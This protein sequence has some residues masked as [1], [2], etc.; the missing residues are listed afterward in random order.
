MNGK[1]LTQELSDHI[2]VVG[3]ILIDENEKNTFI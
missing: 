1:A 2:I 3:A